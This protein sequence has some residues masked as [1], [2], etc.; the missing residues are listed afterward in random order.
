VTVQGWEAIR[1]EVQ[2][3]I[4]IR[5]WPPGAMIPTE[6]ELAAEFG[7]ARGTINRA[8]VE[9]AAAGFL[10]RRRRAGTRVALLPMRQARFAIPVIRAEIETRGMVASHQILAMGRM[11][12]PLPVAARMGRLAEGHLIYLE[13]LHLADGRPFA[14]E[15]RWLNPAVLPDP[16]PDFATISANEWL[17]AN[18]AFVAGDI[19]FAAEAAD[20]RMARALDVASGT[21]VFITE[22]LTRGAE[23]AITFVRLAHVPGYRM[24][25]VL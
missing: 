9:L 1:D 18:V 22:R 5:D 14:H 7:C 19:A 15:Q 20:A 21:P 8:L 11:S 25:T 6:S 2:R 17:V 24:Q 23:A 10:E 16:A 4:R 12:A 3:R 13:T